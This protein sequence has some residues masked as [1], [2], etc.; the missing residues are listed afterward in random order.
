MVFSGRARLVER[1]DDEQECY[2]IDLEIHNDVFGFLFGYRG[3]FTC[4]FVDGP[5]PETVK[6][7]REEARE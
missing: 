6:P 3:A 5:A 2:L 4:E 7:Y 1:Y